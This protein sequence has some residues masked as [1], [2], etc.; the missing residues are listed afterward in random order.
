MALNVQIIYLIKEILKHFPTELD[1]TLW[2]FVRLAL[3]NWVLSVSKSS[4]KLDRFS[5]K[6]FTT[7]VFLLFAELRKFILQENVKSSTELLKNMSTEWENV[8]D[9]EI[10][11]VLLKTFITS[12]AMTHTNEIETQFYSKLSH[13]I[14]WINVEYIFELNKIDSTMTLNDLIEFLIDNV[15]SSIHSIRVCCIKLL[16]NMTAGLIKIDLDL[17][18]QNS[19]K[20]YDEKEVEKTTNWHILHKFLKKLN[21]L[22]L[23]V[24]QYL[25]NYG[26][27]L[28]GGDHD[29]KDAP[30]DRAVPYLLVWDCILFICS[31]APAE[32]RS[33][34]TTWITKN[35][36]E[37]VLLPFLFELMP[38]EILRN[39]D[40][41]IVLGQ[42]MFGK[43]N[44][45]QI[46]S[47]F[48]FLN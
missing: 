17:L 5:V 28:N 31:K 12:V 34:Y 22:E 27:K 10:N 29:E 4:E 25:K 2:D 20:F 33:T 13:A 18:Q 9:K 44:W 21:T 38:R 6:L 40:T 26:F 48:F 35:E 7:A 41:G 37:V 8:F 43:I 16:R 45:K 14:D 32:L 15:D 1:T 24:K 23:E 46:S 3:S 30:Y 42:T 19:D 47:K 11:L 36:L 39:P